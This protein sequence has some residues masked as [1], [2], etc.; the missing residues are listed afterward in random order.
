MGQ[1]VWR[2][3]GRGHNFCLQKSR[4]PT[5]RIGI[6]P[7]RL[8]L[9]C[10]IPAENPVCGPVLQ[11]PVQENTPVILNTQQVLSSRRKRDTS[12]SNTTFLPQDV[13][14]TIVQTQNA[15][16]AVDFVSVHF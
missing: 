2:P 4:M 6:F 5:G 8:M 7:Y 11:A 15:S 3:Y 16:D 12:D 9:Y 13:L 1:I 10:E 14:L